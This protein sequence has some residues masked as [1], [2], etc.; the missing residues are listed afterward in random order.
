MRF[1]PRVI[2]ALLAISMLQTAG[3]AAAPIAEPAISTATTTLTLG[4]AADAW[5][6]SSSPTTNYGSHNRLKVR[7]ASRRFESFLRFTVSGSGTVSA[8]RLRLFVADTSADGGA[9]HLTSGGWSEAGLTWSNRP[10]PVGGP[11]AAIGAAT[12]KAFVEVDLGSA[13]SGDGTYDFVITGGIADA[14]GY[15]SRESSAS[16]RPQLVL[17]TSGAPPQPPQNVTLP[18]VSGATPERAVHFALP[19]AW[20]GDAPISFGYQWLR[21][22]ALCEPIAGA[23]GD[24]H[25]LTDADV[26][27]RLAV[28]VTGTN[29]AGSATAQSAASAPIPPRS[30]PAAGDPV[31]SVAGD[32][33]CD[34]DD[35]GFNGGA[36][37]ATQCRQ[38]ATSDLLVGR[39][40]A[41]VLVP[42]DLQ[43]DSGEYGDFLRSYDASWGRVNGIT[44]PTPGNHEYQTGGAAGYFGYFGDVAGAPGE[45][46]YSFDVGTWHIIGLNSECSGSACAP[47]SAQETWLRQDLASSDAACTLAYWH[48][49]RFS[50]GAHGSDDDV[51]AFWQA[52]YEYGADVVVNGHDHNYERFAPLSPAGAAD[53]EFG[54]REFVV[55][56]GGN[57]LRPIVTPLANSEARNDTDFGVLDLTLRAD[58]YAWDFVPIAGQ[59]YD[60]AGSAS[61]HGPPGGSPPP[62]PPATDFSVAPTGETPPMPHGGDSADDPAIWVHP[63]DP[64]L[65]TVIGTD[66]QPGGGLLVY[67]LAGNQ[68]HA[69]LGVAMNNVDVVDGFPLAGTAVSLVVATDRLNASLAIYRVDPVSRGLVNVAS[70]LVPNAGGGGLCLYRSASTGEFHAFTATGNGVVKQWR[71]FATASS[72]VDAS[73]VRKFDVGD[74]TEG[75]VADDARGHLYVAEEQVGIWRYAAEPTDPSPRLLVAGTGASGHLTPDV[76]GLALVVDD[77][78]GGGFLIASSQGDDR[79]VIFRRNDYAYVASFR[80]V[81]GAHVDGAEST[82]GIEVAALQLGPA[83]PGGLFVAQDGN[84]TDAGAAANH[85]FKLV[86]WDGILAAALA[87]SGSQ[88]LQFDG[89]DF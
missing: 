27:R 86:P 10:M 55:G 83:F 7:T 66:K 26:G 29:G 24:R 73:L 71:L 72:T 17:T 13:I 81:A 32:I 78:P 35:T 28:V 15:H 41:T 75:C 39:G 52:L 20:S 4:S 69:Y 33:A 25:E 34:P 82:D 6:D 11:L 5:V 49:P 40:L 84:N 88:G 31:I 53:P 64:A 65:S 3:A 2:A 57:G 67:D 9:L 70:R 87:A 63:D 14:A 76:E 79:Y 77:S 85:N 18:T 54:I 62:P 1:A 58:G 61:C 60:D 38:A 59:D 48:H 89:G 8:A 16:R 44:R 36:G 37:T 30:S 74:S 12:T 43:Y 50:S 22:D 21:C 45:G 56:T 68:L 23:T 42:G 19:G 51:A 47:G 46:W 80:I